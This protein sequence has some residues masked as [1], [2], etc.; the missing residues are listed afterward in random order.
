MER[1]DISRRADLVRWVVNEIVQNPGIQVTTATLAQWLQISV[2]AAQRIVDH[3]VEAG[4]LRE[5]SS[6]VWS[7]T[8]E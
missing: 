8:A 6:G 3:L 4:V 1:R 7:R 5:V 2:D